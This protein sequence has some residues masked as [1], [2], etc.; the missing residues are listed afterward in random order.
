MKKESKNL[1]I[2]KAC[3]SCRKTIIRDGNFEGKGSFSFKCPHC[4][5]FV[6]IDIN[7]ITTMKVSKRNILISVVVL[8]SITGIGFTYKT[9]VADKINCKTV[10]KP[11]GYAQTLYNQAKKQL[12][13]NP[14]N[15]NNQQV[16]NKL[17]KLDRDNDGLTCE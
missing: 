17:K 8:F 11:K 4:L 5:E 2:S 12:Q 7:P 15:K 14:L 9:L 13:A 6:V 1:G 10:D 16:F 3:P